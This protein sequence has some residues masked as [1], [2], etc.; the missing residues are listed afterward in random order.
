[1]KNF[2]AN[3]KTSAGGI[4]TAALGVASLFNVKIAGAGAIDPQTAIAMIVTGASLIFA[5]D[6]NVTGGTTRQ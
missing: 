2:L 4:L 1:M 6:G 3:W 5:K